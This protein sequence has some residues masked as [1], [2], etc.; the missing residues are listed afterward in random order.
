MNLL[1]LFVSLFVSIGAAG[2]ATLPK[3]DAT[4]NGCLTGS[5]RRR[6]T[7]QIKHTR[8]QPALAK[9]ADNDDNWL[10]K[11]LEAP[12]PS[13]DWRYTLSQAPI[14]S[15]ET[16]PY[17]H[18]E[19]Y[20]YSPRHGWPA[21]NPAPGAPVQDASAGMHHLK[22]WDSAWFHPT[23]Y[24]K[25]EY[26]HSTT[27]TMPPQH[28]E[29]RNHQNLN[30]FN[31][32]PPA[33]Q[34]STPQHQPLSTTRPHHD[35]H[36]AGWNEVIP[37]YEDLM[38]SRDL[39]QEDFDRVMTQFYPSV[40]NHPGEEGHDGGSSS[41]QTAAEGEDMS[42]AG[43]KRKTKL[44]DVN[45]YQLLTKKDLR[46]G[47]KFLK[48]KLKRKPHSYLHSMEEFEK[49]SKETR[50]EY[51]NWNARRNYM[52]RQEKASAKKRES[53]FVQK[54]AEDEQMRLHLLRKLRAIDEKR[55]KGSS[56]DV[57]DTLMTREISKVTGDKGK[58][59][60]FKYNKVF[61]LIEEYWR[62]DRNVLWMLDLNPLELSAKNSML[63]GPYQDSDLQSSSYMNKRLQAASRKQDALAV[64]SQSCSTSF[65]A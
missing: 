31:S 64:A 19:E 59:L 12:S 61:P 65:S 41:H 39:T 7:P 63:S 62:R 33:H 13:Q 16:K 32:Q 46:R 20:S 6:Q 23:T 5:L 35:K 9:R 43:A 29:Q 45:T 44:H 47:L 50:K 57:R 51:K 56:W 42:G 60:M 52:L 53:E 10:N 2:A 21:Q 36:A 22:S 18:D 30:S 24:P 4:Q 3:E 49:M 38:R 34:P 48:R 55:Q 15:P 58:E 28:I 17:H 8:E 26:S 40:A 11:V 54:P 25:S 27:S 14:A 37:M 1:V